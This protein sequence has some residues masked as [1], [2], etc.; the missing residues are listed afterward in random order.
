MAN[1]RCR[2]K[3][4]ESL[5]GPEGPVHDTLGILK[6]AARYYK[7]LFSWESRGTSCI[8]EEFWAP[9]EKVTSSKRDELEA[10]FM[11]EEVKADVFNSYSEGAPDPDGL[12]YLLY[13]KFWDIIKGDLMKLVHDFQEGKLD[14]FR[15]N[16]AT[17]T[18]IPKVEEASEMKNYRPISLLNYSFIIFGRLLTSRLKK[19]SE[20]LVAPEQGAFI[21]GRYILESVAIAHEIVHNLHNNKEPGVIIK[22]DYGKAYDR[23]NLEFVFEILKLRGFGDTWLGWIKKV[24]LGGYVSVMANGEENSP[25]KTG[26]GLRQG[27]C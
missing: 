27:M 4:V 25:F 10:P 19:V 17:L 12:S 11:I 24:V 14:L 3:R 13:P 8:D 23:I 16:F 20:I 22:L 15:I 21:Q 7:D 1:H 18:L 2:K 26:K 6:V 5:N 9:K